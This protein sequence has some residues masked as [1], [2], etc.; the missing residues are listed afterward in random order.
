MKYRIAKE[1]DLNAIT[2]IRFS[3]SE[4]NCVGIFASLGRPF[5]K[6]Y[7]KLILK[8]KDS[9]FICAEDDSGQI[10]G[11]NFIILDSVRHKKYLKRHIFY[12]AISAIMSIIQK[13]VLI[14]RLLVR[15]KSLKKN[16]N[17]FIHDSG[18]RGGYWGWS[19]TSQD[20]ISS[21]ELHERTLEIAKILGVNELFFEVDTAN[22]NV[23]KFHK[24]N[25]AIIDQI[26]TLPDGRE[27]VFMK[28]VLY[29]RISKFLI[30]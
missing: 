19:P 25:G 16:N 21:I 8:D 4:V 12:L 2:N 28:Y 11:F 3:I 22:K 26:I 7:Y 15:Y 17:K 24:Y 13:P 20:S 9:I 23:L 14:E 1:C 27:R 10:K 30:Q 6:A 29:N 18:V 5:L